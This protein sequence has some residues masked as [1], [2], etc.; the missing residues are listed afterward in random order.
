MVTYN[1]HHWYIHSTR[2]NRYFVFNIIEFIMRMVVSKSDTYS[3]TM[4]I[5]HVQH[6]T[7][8]Y[9]MAKCFFSPPKDESKLPHT[10]LCT[11]A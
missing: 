2:A 8:V 9:L 4:H 5:R 6:M 7:R 11:P 1:K 3:H 10:Q